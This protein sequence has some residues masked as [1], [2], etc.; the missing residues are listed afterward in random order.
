[1]G[2]PAQ[3]VQ[4]WIPKVPDA[5]DDMGLLLKAGI[6]GVRLR[7]VEDLGLRVYKA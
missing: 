6:Q 5:K 2:F 4:T 7:M 3:S 1:M